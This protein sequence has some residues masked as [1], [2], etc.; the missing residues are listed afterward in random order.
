[1]VDMSKWPDVKWDN[2][3]YVATVNG[4]RC[5]AVHDG[6]SKQWFAVVDGEILGAFRDHMKARDA[7]E[8]FASGAMT[9]KEVKR[10]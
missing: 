9:R 8:A 7:C 3:G 10:L 4:K 5:N 1:M 2:Q 6:L